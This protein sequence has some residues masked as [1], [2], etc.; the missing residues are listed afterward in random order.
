MTKKLENKTALVTGASKGIGAAIAIQ[1]AKEGAKVIVNY[2]SDKAGAERVVKEIEKLG[3]KAEA[4]KANLSLEEEIK[5]LGQAIQ[6]TFGKLDILVNN[7]GIYETSNVEQITP[8]HFYKLFDLNVLGLLLTTQEA[9]RYFNE[10]GG[11]IINISSVAAHSG[12]SGF[13]VY[14]ATKGAVDS[15]TRALAAELGPR[16]IRVNAINPGMIETEGLIAAG[17]QDS[18][19]KKK[20]EE[21]TPLQRLGKPFDVAPLAAFLASNE[22]S[23]ITGE[24]FVISG[25]HK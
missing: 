24:T 4:V 22:S 3:S 2:S 12:I 6:Q 5:T 23:W 13:S 20:L 19:L 15:L 16:Q 11:S 1:L 10:A 21:E 17:F 8:E 7:A 9:L 18:P 14:S 25:G